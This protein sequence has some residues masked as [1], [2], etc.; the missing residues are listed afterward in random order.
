MMHIYYYEYR[1]HGSNL[2]HMVL[3]IKIMEMRLYV[4]A[5]DHPYH[6]SVSIGA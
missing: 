4:V 1:I 3:I 5:Y 2:H 6:V